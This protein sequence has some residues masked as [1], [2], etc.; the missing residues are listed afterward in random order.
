MK[1][2]L[3]NQF[4]MDEYQGVLRV[5]TTVQPTLVDKPMVGG[6]AVDVPAADVPAADAPASSDVI[7][8]TPGSSTSAVTTSQSQVTTLKLVGDSLV[9]QGVISGLGKGEQ[10]RG[11]RFDRADLGYVVTFRQTDPLFTIDLRPPPTPR[12]PAS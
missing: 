8:A 1:G 6:P 7:V 11:V 4:A 10:I 5:A 12:W 2:H 9:Q 3:L